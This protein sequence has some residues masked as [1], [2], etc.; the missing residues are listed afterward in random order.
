MFEE[1]LLAPLPNLGFIVLAAIGM[2]VAVI[3]FTKLAGL[4]SF[5]K[6]S[7][8]DFAMTVAIGS[9][10]ATT[11]VAKNPPLLQGVVALAALYGLQKLVSNLRRFDWVG[12]LVDNRPVLLMRHGEMF[13][14]NMRS[15][16]VTEEDLRSKLR[17]ANVL[18]LSQV[19]AVVFETTGDISVLH[20]KDTD[21][22]LEGWLLEGVRDAESH[23][24]MAGSPEPRHVSA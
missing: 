20:T 12:N 9:L 1:W 8:F 5:S 19:R 7:S 15:T 17:E 6:M 10:V 16:G 13:L 4:R 11:V 18:E 21:V 23:I 14:D 2:Y 24:E 22:E 3:I